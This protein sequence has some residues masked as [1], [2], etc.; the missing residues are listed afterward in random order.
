MAVTEYPIILIDS[1]DGAASDSNCS[2]AGPATALT[3]TAASTD[4]GGTVITLDG[5]PDLSGVNTDGSH[6]IFCNDASGRKWGAINA[7]DD[8]ADTVTVEQA[9]TGSQSNLNWAIGGVR[10]TVFGSDSLLLIDDGGSAGQGEAGWIFEMQSG[11]T[12]STSVTRNFRILGSSGW[13]QGCPQL[14][15]ASGAATKPVITQTGSSAS[16]VAL[17][18]DAS[19]WI[20]KDFDI[21]TSGSNA[22]GVNA[23]VSSG[24]IFDSME[25]REGTFS[26]QY[27]ISLT[28][29][30]GCTVTNCR[31]IGLQSG[32]TI[33]TNDSG[34]AFTGN[35][36]ENCSTQGLN[37]GAGSPCLIYACIFVGCTIGFKNDYAPNANGYVLHCVFDDCDDAIV[38]DQDGDT[39]N[40]FKM[41]YA[42]NQIANSSDTGIH[43]T[44]AATDTSIIFQ[45]QMPYRVRNN[46]TYNCTTARV[47]LDTNTSDFN[48]LFGTDS[49]QP[50]QE[51]IAATRLS[52]EDWTHNSSVKEKGYPD[53][54]IGETNT[55]PY[56]D[57]GVPRKEF[58]WIQRPVSGSMIGR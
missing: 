16:V 29:S 17:G 9:F 36:F 31:F 54:V 38:S 13:T 44:D 56:V 55:R 24:H 12:E 42:N 49:Y 41:F 33:G 30:S 52:S 45:Q 22:R 2:G 23:F 20:F 7:K 46:N 51:T 1:T 27:G 11:H 4:S 28:S 15:G 5:S 39:T 57:Q 19:G 25:F 14:R 50:F 35:Y 34:H 48:D 47:Q 6:V 3:G 18:T 21:V 43:F 26:G 8:G 37:L 40:W 58:G 10:S 53:V 32:I